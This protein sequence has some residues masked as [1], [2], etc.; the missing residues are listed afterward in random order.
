MARV[1]PHRSVD[2]IAPPDAL[3]PLL[4]SPIACVYVRV[5][6]LPP[7][8]GWNQSINQSIP[9]GEA[10][11]TT[12]VCL[13]CSVLFYS[14]SFCVCLC[15]YAQCLVPVLHVTSR[16]VHAMRCDAM[17]KGCKA[18]PSRRS[19]FVCIGLPLPFPLLLLCVRPACALCLSLSVPFPFPFPFPRPVPPRPRPRPRSRCL[20]AA[21]A[22][23][24]L[25]LHLL[26]SA[27]PN[28]GSLHLTGTPPPPPP[29][30]LGG[31]H[32]HHDH[33][34]GRASSQRLLDILWRDGW[35]WAWAC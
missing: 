26:C 14:V 13:F 17:A 33:L 28:W 16:H 9:I 30:G 32:Q 8:C 20:R 6:L 31:A 12:R 25:H 5:F 3:S 11:N 22:F 4:S 23:Y 35:A 2:S 1:H 7:S 34:D 29:L 21:A 27:P 10:H 19:T 15:V 24:N 18:T